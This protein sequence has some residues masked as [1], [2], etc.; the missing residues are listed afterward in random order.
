MEDNSAWQQLFADDH[1]HE[2]GYLPLPADSLG[3]MIWPL[4]EWHELT[5]NPLALDL[6]V[7]IAHTFVQYHPMRSNDM[8]PVGCFGNNHGVLNASPDAL[9][10]ADW[11]TANHKNDGVVLAIEKFVLSG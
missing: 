1:P 8:C 3:G 6:A 9:A 10:V 5:G 11:I 7:G 2:R 4:V